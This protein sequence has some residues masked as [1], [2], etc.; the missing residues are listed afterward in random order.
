M[1]PK[2]PIRYLFVLKSLV[3]LALLA[4]LLMVPGGAQAQ[5]AGICERTPEVRDWILARLSATDCATITTTR[6]NGFSGTNVA[7]PGGAPGDQL[8]NAIEITGYSSPTLLSSDFEGLTN[9][10][11]KAVVIR[12]S[13]ALRAVPADAFDELSK[14][15]LTDVFLIH[16]GIKAIAPGAFSGMTALLTLGLWHNDIAVL[17]DGVFSGLTAL[18]EL[19]LSG[20]RLSA[21]PSGL[22]GG[23][24]S[25]DV[26][27]L[28]SNSL[29]TLPEDIFAG[30]G[31]GTIDLA[32]NNIATLPADVFDTVNPVSLDLGNNE[33][34]TLDEDIFD[35]LTNL[36]FLSLNGNGLTTLPTDLFDPLDNSLN[37]LSLAGNSITTLHEDIFDGLTG[38]YSLLMHDNSLTTLP[39]DLFDGLT[40]LTTLHLQENSIT[41][42]LR[43]SSTASV[44][45]SISVSPATNSQRSKPTC[46]IPWTTA[47]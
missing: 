36:Q 34:T 22:F 23:L 5:D 29:T 47:C 15:S 35:G 12:D 43:P 10:G 13:P 8:M 40:G 41:T 46:S 1:N 11:I 7:H 2:H 25:L 32:D 9:T 45:S 4:A 27:N 16:N 20:N 38:L 28:S 37:G 17:H 19:D 39:A 18:L 21:L 30:I 33:L 24:T 31:P 26:L 6:L 44:T 3:A 42:L 14:G